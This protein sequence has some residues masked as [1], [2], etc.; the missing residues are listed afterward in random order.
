MATRSRSSSRSSA[1]T[2]GDDGAGV[3]PGGAEAGRRTP[4]ADRAAQGLTSDADDVTD[5]LCRRLAEEG[6]KLD[7][8]REGRKV[9]DKKHADELQALRELPRGP[10]QAGDAARRLA[11]RRALQIWRARAHAIDSHPLPRV[12]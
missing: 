11:A 1:R 4:L 12:A 2:T 3:C 6:K 7:A 8:I 9:T 10:A 5:A